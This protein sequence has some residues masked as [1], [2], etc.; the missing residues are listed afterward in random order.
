MGILSVNFADISGKVKPMHAVNNGPT[1]GVGFGGQNSGGYDAWR[2]AGI[3]YARTHD[4]SFCAAYGGEH[5]VDI[6]AVFPNFDA[7]ADDPASYDFAVTDAYMQSIQSCGTKVFYRLGSKIEHEVKKYNIH[8]PK[9]FHKWARICEHVI[10]HYT[11]GWA[12]GFRYDM[13][14][15]EIWNE[16]DLDPEDSEKR[17]TWTGTKQQFF[18]LFAITATH[19]KACFPHLKIGGPASAYREGW[20]ADFLAYLTQDGKRVPLDFFSWHCYGHRVEKM[21]E[22]SEF[23]R[24]ILDKHGYTHTE[25]I[26]NEWNYIRSWNDFIYSMQQII[27][28]K[29]A[30]FTAACMCGC[31][32][33]SAIDMLMYYDARPSRYNGLFDFYTNAPLKGYYPFKMFNELYRLEN[34]C[35]CTAEDDCLYAA[36]ARSDAGSAVMISYFTDDDTQ[37]DCRR[38]RLALSNGAAEYNVILLDGTHNAE[39]VGAVMADG[40]ITLQPNTVC[41]LRSR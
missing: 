16:P 32:N 23:V 31:Q 3:P 34:A 29:G 33:N 21:Y 28:I 30:A 1:K 37:T 13:T 39:T 19:L 26:L 35:C 11:E 4:S 22:R 17:R 15:W 8:P 12:E 14:Y 7:D 25:S 38:I 40:E 2:A 20:I 5:T 10:R 41:L 9:D 24:N 18:E 6:H 36:A 27:S